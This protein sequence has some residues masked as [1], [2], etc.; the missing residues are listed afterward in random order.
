MSRWKLR[1]S[2]PGDLPAS[3]LPCGAFPRK[4]SASRERQAGYWWPRTS[5]SFTDCI[6]TL[7]DI[8]F[9]TGSQRGRAVVSR[10]GAV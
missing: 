6:A 8:G 1:P 10:S 5:S 7:Y 3:K 4:L 2:G 9:R